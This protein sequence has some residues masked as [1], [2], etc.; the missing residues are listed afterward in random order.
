MKKLLVYPALFTFVLFQAQLVFADA[1]GDMMSMLESMKQQ[2]AK[3]QTTIDQQSLRLQQLESHKVLEG[4]QPAVALGPDGAQ[5]YLAE[6]DWQSG[7]K[8]NIGKAIPWLK[9]A[10]YGGGIPL[11]Y[12]GV[13]YAD[14]NNDAGSTGTTADRSRNRF[15]IR[16]RWGFEKDYGDDWKFGFRL[17]TGNT[18]DPNS[19]NQTLGNAGYFTFKNFLVDKAY[20]TYEPNGLKDYGLI[21]A[22]KIGAGKVDN[23]FIRY[24]TP[25]VWDGDVTP[26][27]LYEQATVQLLSTEDNK[28]NF[29]ATAGQL[30]VNEN[31]A[32][33][34]DAGLYGYQG[35]LTLSTYGFGTEQPV[36]FTGAASFYDYTNWF[37]TVTSNTVAV[38][39]FFFYH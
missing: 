4:P 12:Q 16:L 7:I 27:G 24:S 29:T 22:V 21:K 20:V 36:D 19:T 14:K 31:A 35:A 25:I 3:M 8:D 10:K 9:G 26:E 39:S 34:S 6:K 17:A 18:T 33:E 37:Q 15:R 32:L 1:S 28:L 11:P 13:G 5:P 2:M 30:I 38:P 23:P